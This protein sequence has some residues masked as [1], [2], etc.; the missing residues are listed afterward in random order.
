MKRLKLA[1]AAF[2]TASVLIAGTTGVA[3]AKPVSQD[4][5][6]QWSEGKCGRVQRALDA[7]ADHINDVEEGEW[8]YDGNNDA[9]LINL[10]A[11]HA[12]VQHLWFLG[13]CDAWVVAGDPATYLEGL[14]AGT[15]SESP[16]AG[17]PTAQ[18]GSLMALNR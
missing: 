4:G 7:L 13:G 9:L 15:V 11:L 1:A 12:R 14:G 18:A 10:Y 16:S 6:G 17:V 3:E 8:P 2:I 5:S